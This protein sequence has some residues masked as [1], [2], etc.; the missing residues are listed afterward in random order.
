MIKADM[1]YQ[2]DGRL[3]EIMMRPHE[4]FGGV[5]VLLLGNLLQLQPVKGKYIFEEPTDDSWKA[6][7]A[8]QSLWEL[9]TP[10]K[11]T[12]NHRQAG[13]A[14]FAEMLKNF[15]RGIKTDDDINRL[16]TRV[17]P[18]NDPNIPMDTLYI[19]PTKEMVKRYNEQQLS[20]LEGDLEVLEA[21]NILTTKKYFD[22]PVDE[23]DGK[24]RGTPL[25]NVLYLKKEARIVLIHNVDISD[26]LNNG[27]KGKVLSFIKKD[28][29][30]TH[31]MVEFDDENAGK[32][33][34]ESSPIKTY[35]ERNNI[36]GIPIPRITFP[37]NIS[38]KQHQD[39]QKALCIQFPLQLGY[40]LTIHKMQ[41]TTVAPPKTLTSDFSKIFDGSQAYTVLSRIKRL[42]QLFL[43]NDVY[44]DKIYTN[45][46]PLKTLK[47]L[48]SKAINANVIGRRD[49]QIKIL[50]MNTQN[51]IHHIEDVKGHP[52]VT[53][54]N[55][56][57]LSETWLSDS[58][59]LGNNH[60]YQIAN[61]HPHYIN[62]GNERESHR[63][64][65]HNSNWKKHLTL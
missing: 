41:G 65:S 23:K 48:E 58:L 18:E 14:E 57:F 16:T 38:K 15:S 32:A 63:F 2:I 4:P 7:H 19:F 8:W 30:V 28:D 9:F 60:P 44:R 20:R 12:Y 22:P 42:D 1:L 54:H 34:R 49:D 50:C 62:I 5:S 52:K 35:L 31:I 33:L 53:E 45:Q 24:V 6:G 21:T 47:D 61:Y 64:L 36:P 3:K 27:A 46:K 25:A 43:L 11:A 37:Y 56:I 17:F 55:L 26:G 39:G 51:L 29:A 13:E 10:I 40:A 59:T